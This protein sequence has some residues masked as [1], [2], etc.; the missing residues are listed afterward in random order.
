MPFWNISDAHSNHHSGSLTSS[1]SVMGKYFGPIAAPN[2]GVPNLMSCTSIRS[3]R[4]VS[5]HPV[6][7][8]MLP[9]HVPG[10]FSGRDIVYYLCTVS[11]AMGDVSSM[12]KTCCISIQF[13][14]DSDSRRREHGS[15]SEMTLVSMDLQTLLWISSGLLSSVWRTKALEHRK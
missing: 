11:E 1:D 13:G 2:A 7:S 6:I 14:K 10:R 8:M 5:T 9:G 4:Q 3:I 15:R 12:C